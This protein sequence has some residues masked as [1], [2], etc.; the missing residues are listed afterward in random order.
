MHTVQITSVTNSSP[1]VELACPAAAAATP[2]AI[3]IR[4]TMHTTRAV[5]HFVLVAI[6]STCILASYQPQRIDKEG[7]G[8][9]DIR[10]LSIQRETNI[11]AH[12]TANVA[13]CV[14][15]RDEQPESVIDWIRY[16]RVLVGG[17]C[18]CPRYT[19]WSS[20]SHRYHHYI[21]VG[22][23]YIYDHSTWGVRGVSS[24]STRKYTHYMHPRFAPSVRYTC[25]K[26]L[27]DPHPQ[28]LGRCY[29]PQHCR[30]C[31]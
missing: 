10:H 13:F 20:C 26:L 31:S 27:A 14:M 21:G 28:W 29:H 1:H 4:C 6:C 22:K 7:T 9:D 16:I 5:L 8:S 3:G 12:N 18:V 19:T 23:F 17:V 15:L 24:T 25:S 30:R 2:S 11:T